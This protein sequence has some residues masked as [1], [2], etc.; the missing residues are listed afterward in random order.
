MQE[1]TPRK[2][3]YFELV[4]GRHPAREDLEGIRDKVSRRRLE[5]RILKLEL[6][7]Y[8][9]HRRIDGDFLE[10]IADFGPGYRIYLGEDGPLLVLILV[11]GDKSTQPGDFKEARAYWDLYKARKKKG[12]G[13]GNA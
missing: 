5:L 13:H 11:V 8:G 4:P 2:I 9:Q 12:K 1:A 6:G 10:L 3:E 7:N